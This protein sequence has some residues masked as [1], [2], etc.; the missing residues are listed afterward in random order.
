MESPSIA[1]VGAGPG[2]L[3]LARV[4]QVH[5]IRSTVYELEAD[6]KAR[7]QGGMFDIHEDHGQRA[8]RV[9][10]LFEEFT[11][12]ARPEADSVRILDKAGSLV[13]EDTAAGRPEI[14]RRHLREMLLD[15]VDAG[16]IAWGRKLQEANRLPDGQS[17]LVFADGGRETVGLLI[18]ADGAWSRVRPLVTEVRPEYTGVTF[19]E[20]VLPDIDR[21][22]PTLSKLVGAGS[23]FA[24]APGRGI[25]AQRNSGGVVR[26][27][28][29]LFVPIDWLAAADAD[30]D[31]SPLDRQLLLDQYAGWSPEL[32]SL[33]RYPDEDEM[34]TRR[35]Y[36]M[37]VGHAWSHV[38]GV[39]LIGD[40]AHLMSPFGG[41]GANLAMLDAAE[42]GAVIAASPNDLDAAVLSFELE[43]FRRTEPVAAE[44]AGITQGT[45]GPD[46]PHELAVAMAMERGGG[47]LESGED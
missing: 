41:H 2:G 18:G 29:A 31:E 1:I 15:S 27:G 3:L 13:Y 35:L 40:A 43:M 42:L 21:R 11:R 4:L 12:L 28:A 22:Y 30:D 7:G 36:A 19:V 9:A 24:V 38:P 26:V 16:T 37:P 44:S 39:T 6:P 20:F 33:I 32:T 25:V 34:V 10:G 45:F 14:D 47:K 23:M 8:L 5:G 17:E 46:A